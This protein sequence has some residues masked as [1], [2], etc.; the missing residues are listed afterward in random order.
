MLDAYRARGES[1]MVQRLEAAPVS[2]T[3]GLSDAYMRRRDDAMHGLGVGTMR[4]M[5]SVVAGVFLPVGRC[6]AYTLLEKI[7]V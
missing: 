6:Q 2:M 1:V 3:D 5:R 4:D 7:N